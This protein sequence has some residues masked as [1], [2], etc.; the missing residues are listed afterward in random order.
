[1]QQSLD[2]L[3]PRLEVESLQLSTEMNASA[4]DDEQRFRLLSSKPLR[5]E[6]L[7][8]SVSYQ[9]YNKVL[10]S[11]KTR[12][13]SILPDISV[14]PTSLIVL[15][16]TAKT[17]SC[18]PH[19]LSD[20]SLPK[21][22][23]LRDPESMKA[24]E[25]FDLTQWSDRLAFFDIF[26]STTTSR[27]HIPNNDQTLKRMVYSD[28]PF[29]CEGCHE[30]YSDFLAFASHILTC[31][32]TLPPQRQSMYIR[33][34]MSYLKE[35][36]KDLQEWISLLVNVKYS[37]SGDQVPTFIPP[38]LPNTSGIQL[39]T[40][41]E[42]R[43]PTLL[44]LLKAAF[45][46][47]RL[48]DEIEI[49]FTTHLLPQ[50]LDRLNNVYQ[51]FLEAFLSVTSDSLTT[52]ED[53][54][55]HY[56]DQLSE[57]LRVATFASNQDIQTTGS[58]Y[59]SAITI[60]EHLTT[61]DDIQHFNDVVENFSES[62]S[63]FDSLYSEILDNNSFYKSLTG[64]PLSESLLQRMKK[65]LKNKDFYKSISATFS[66][67]T[68]IVE[69]SLFTDHLKTI[70]GFTLGVQILLQS[71]IELNKEVQNDT[72]NQLNLLTLRAA[73]IGV[74][75]KHINQMEDIKNRLDNDEVILTSHL[76]FRSTQYQTAFTD[77]SLLALEDLIQE[78]KQLEYYSLLFNVYIEID[79][80]KQKIRAQHYGEANLADIREWMVQC[81]KKIDKIKEAYDRAAQVVTMSEHTIS[82]QLKQEFQNIQL[83]FNIIFDTSHVQ[84]KLRHWKLLSDNLNQPAIYL[85]AIDTNNET[86]SPL[87][88]TLIDANLSD[89]TDIY[90]NVVKRALEELSVDN[91]FANLQ[92]KWK[93]K[94]VLKLIPSSSFA[95][96]DISESTHF[97]H[98]S[99]TEEEVNL[100]NL[101]IQEK[102]ILDAQSEAENAVLTLD[103]IMNIHNALST[104]L[105]LPLFKQSVSRLPQLLQQ[106][107]ATQNTWLTLRGFLSSRYN[108]T[109]L[110]HILPTFTTA[111]AIWAS[112]I[113]KI[114]NDPH[115]Y[116]TIGV[117]E[118]FSTILSISQDKLNE[119][120]TQ[121]R[122]FVMAMHQSFPLFNLITEKE[123]FE[124]LSYVPKP[125]HLLPI[126]RRIFPGL[127][128]LIYDT[129]Q[130]RRTRPYHH[131]SDHFIEHPLSQSDSHQSDVNAQKPRLFDSFDLDL[132][133]FN[134]LQDKSD[135][136]EPL[137]DK[138]TT[139]LSIDSKHTEN[140]ALKS[141]SFTQMTH[142][143]PTVNEED[144]NLLATIQDN[145]SFG[146]QYHISGITEHFKFCQDENPFPT[147]CIVGIIGPLQ[148][149]VM[150]THSVSFTPHQNSIPFYMALHSSLKQSIRA[151]HLK[152]V[153]RIYPT[154]FAFSRS[155]PDSSESMSD[156]PVSSLQ[157]DLQ[158]PKPNQFIDLSSHNVIDF[159]LT[160]RDHPRYHFEYSRETAD[161]PSML[162]SF[163]TQSIYFS[164]FSLSMFELYRMLMNIL[165]RMSA[166]DSEEW[167]KAYLQIHD[168]NGFDFAPLHS[169]LGRHD[170]ASYRGNQSLPEMVSGLQ[171]LRT[172]FI[173]LTSTIQKTISHRISPLHR[174]RI[175][176]AL[177]ALWPVIAI[178]NTITPL[179]I[180]KNPASVLRALHRFRSMPI[181]NISHTT[182]STR[183]IQETFSS[184]LSDS[185]RYL[186]EK[187]LRDLN[188]LGTYY[189]PIQPP[190][191]LDNVT[192]SDINVSFKHLSIPYGFDYLALSLSSV[193]SFHI[194]TL[195][196]PMHEAFSP[197]LGESE[198]YILATTH[199]WESLVS[200]IVSVFPPSFHTT[201]NKTDSIRNWS[202]H[203]NL[204]PHFTALLGDS[205]YTLSDRIVEL[206]WILGRRV[207]QLT[208]S[209]ESTINETLVRFLKGVVEGGLFG[210]IDGVSM[211]KH[212]N[213]IELA[214]ILNAISEAV[215]KSRSSTIQNII[216]IP[217]NPNFFHFFVSILRGLDPPQLPPELRAQ[218]RLVSVSSTPPLANSLMHLYLN[219]FQYS[220]VLS[221][222]IDHF[223]QQYSLI[224]GQSPN[225]LFG[226]QNHISRIAT[227]YLD[228]VI[229]D[230]FLPVC[231]TSHNITSVTSSPLFKQYFRSTDGSR[232]V[233]IRQDSFKRTDENKNKLR[234]LLESL[235]VCYGLVNDLI[236]LIN[237][238]NV[239]SV[240]EL[241]NNLFPEVADI[242]IDTF[243]F[244]SVST[245]EDSFVMSFNRPIGSALVESNRITSIK[246]LRNGL[247]TYLLSQT[248]F[249]LLQSDI[250]DQLA[251]NLVSINLATMNRMS[252]P[253]VNL[254]RVEQFMMMMK[255][256]PGSSRDYDGVSNQSFTSDSER[257]PPLYDRPSESPPI[258]NQVRNI[259]AKV[260]QLYTLLHPH[261]NLPGAAAAIPQIAPVIVVGPPGSGKTT[262]IML[263]ALIQ[264]QMKRKTRLLH[265]NPGSISIEQLLGS[266]T[267]SMNRINPEAS[268]LSDQ[269]ENLIRE[270]QKEMSHS[271]SLISI[272]TQ[273][274]SNTILQDRPEFHM[275]TAKGA[276]SQN[277]VF[278]PGVVPT[279]LN[280]MTQL[281]A[282]GADS[283][284][285]HTNES[286]SLFDEFFFVLDTSSPLFA[287]PNVLADQLPSSPNTLSQF[288]PSAGWLL[289]TLQWIRTFS[290]FFR[291]TSRLHNSVSTSLIRS[292]LY[293]AIHQKSEN[294]GG[295]LVIPE[296][297][298]DLSIETLINQFLWDDAQSD[299][300]KD[301]SLSHRSFSQIEPE[302]SKYQ[303]FLLDINY[304]DYLLR[305]LILPNNQV[306]V[307]PHNVHYIIETDSLASLPSYVISN[308][309]ILYVP[310]SLFTFYQCTPA[311]YTIKRE[312]M[313]AVLYNHT[314]KTLISHIIVHQISSHSFL[315]QDVILNRTYRLLSNVANRL[316]H[317][318]LK[319]TEFVRDYFDTNKH[320][321][322]FKKVTPLN[323]QERPPHMYNY[324]S[325]YFFNNALRVF[326]SQ[327]K[328]LANFIIYSVISAQ[329]NI[330]ELKSL[331]QMTDNYQ[332]ADERILVAPQ[333]GLMNALTY[334]LFWGPPGV[335]L[336]NKTAITPTPRNSI[337][338]QD[339]GLFIA[340]TTKSTEFEMTETL[341]D[342]FVNLRTG[343]WEHLVNYYKEYQN[344]LAIHR[345][346]K[347]QIR[348][349]RKDGPGLV[350][351][352]MNSPRSTFLDPFDG[353]SMSFAVSDG[354]LSTSPPGSQMHEFTQ[355]SSSGDAYTD[356]KV[357]VQIPQSILYRLPYIHLFSLFIQDDRPFIAAFH[358]N[359][360]VMD[361]LRSIP[362]VPM[363]VYP[364]TTTVPFVATMD[365][366]FFAHTTSYTVARAFSLFNTIDTNV[367]TQFR[368][369]PGKSSPSQ[370]QPEPY[371]ENFDGMMDV[372][373]T[374]HSSSMYDD[375]HSN[376]S[377]GSFGGGS[378]YS[379]RDID[380]Q[381]ESL[382]YE[383]MS[384]NEDGKPANNNQTSVFENKCMLGIFHY[385][386]PVPS[387]T[388][389]QLRA[390]LERRQFILEN[391]HSSVVERR[392][393][394]VRIA[395]SIQNPFAHTLSPRLGRHFQ[396]VALN[397]ISLL[398]MSQYLFTLFTH[399]LHKD[400]D[401]I[402]PLDSQI[403]SLS[404]ADFALCRVPSIT[405]ILLLLFSGSISTIE[406]K[407]DALKTRAKLRELCPTFQVFP[408]TLND[409]V[410]VFHRMFIQF[411]KN[412]KIETDSFQIALTWITEARR[413]FC[414]R[415]PPRERISF[416]ALA[417]TLASYL[418]HQ[419]QIDFDR[420]GHI[421]DC[422]PFVNE[423]ECIRQFLA[424]EL[425][426][427]QARFFINQAEDPE[428]SLGKYLSQSLP[429]IMRDGL[430]YL[431][432]VRNQRVAERLEKSHVAIISDPI[433]FQLEDL[434]IVTKLMKASHIYL[435]ITPSHDHFIRQLRQ[436]CVKVFRNDDE[437]VVAAINVSEVLTLINTTSLFHVQENQTVPL[438]DGS[439]V[440]L[441]TDVAG[442]SVDDYTFMPKTHP[443]MNICDFNPL[444]MF[445]PS[446]ARVGDELTPTDV[447]I[448]LQLIITTPS[449]LLYLLTDQDRNIIM[450]NWMT[451]SNRQEIIE[452][453]RRKLRV[454]FVFT[455]YRGRDDPTSSTRDAEVY[456]QRR[457]H[458]YNLFTESV[459][460]VLPASNILSTFA[461]QV[462]RFDTSNT[463]T[464]TNNPIITHIIVPGLSFFCWA[465]PLCQYEY[466]ETTP[467]CV[468]ES[469]G[470]LYIV[471]TM[472][473]TIHT[474]SHNAKALICEKTINR[475]IRPHNL[476]TKILRDDPT[477]SLELCRSFI[478]I[479]ETYSFN[480]DE[481][482]TS[483]VHD[484]THF[485]T[486]FSTRP[487]PQPKPTYPP[488]PLLNS[489][490][491]VG[492]GIPRM[493]RHKTAAFSTPVEPES[494]FSLNPD[495]DEQIDQ[496]LLSDSPHTH[497]SSGTANDDSMVFDPDHLAVPNG[498]YQQLKPGVVVHPAVLHALERQEERR[499]IFLTEQHPQRP[500]ILRHSVEQRPNLLHRFPSQSTITTMTSGEI[501]TTRLSTGLR[502]GADNHREHL[503]AGKKQPWMNEVERLEKVF[504][505][506]VMRVFVPNDSSRSSLV[507]Q[508]IH[509]LRVERQKLYV[510]VLIAIFVHV[511][512]SF[513]FYSR[514]HASTEWVK[515]R[516]LLLNPSL[517]RKFLQTFTSIYFKRMEVLDQYHR[518][519]S[520]CSDQLAVILTRTEPISNLIPR[521]LNGSFE[522]ATQHG[523]LVQCIHLCQHLMG[524]IRE[525]QPITQQQ[526]VRL[527]EE[528]K[529]KMGE[530]EAL[531][532]EIIVQTHIIDLEAI[533]QQIESG[534]P[535]MTR[536]V[537][538][539]H[540][541]AR[542]VLDM[543]L[544]LLHKPLKPTELFYIRQKR[545]NSGSSVRQSSIVFIRD[546]VSQDQRYV[547]QSSFIHDVLSAKTRT[548][549][550]EQAELVEP[551]IDFLTNRIDELSENEQIVDIFTYV[552]KLLQCRFKVDTA[553]FQ[554][555]KT[556]HM[557]KSLEGNI[558]TM[559]ELTRELSNY[560]ILLSTT[561]HFLA[562]AACLERHGTEFDSIHPSHS[563]D[564]PNEPTP[565]LSRQSEDDLSARS[566]Y[567]F[568][569]N[570]S[571]IESEDSSIPDHF[572][573]VNPSLS[574]T[575]TPSSMN[576]EVSSYL[577]EYW[578][579]QLTNI[580]KNIINA[581][582]DSILAAAFSVFQ[583]AIP[584]EE[585][586]WCIREW[587]KIL[588]MA[589]IE[590]SDEETKDPSQTLQELSSESLLS[591][592]P[593]LSTIDI[594]YG[595]GVLLYPQPLWV[596]SNFIRPLF[597][598]LWKILHGPSSFWK[599]QADGL[600]PDEQ[601]VLNGCL[602]A[603]VEGVHPIIFVDPLH[604]AQEWM[605]KRYRRISPIIVT[606]ILEKSFFQNCL[607]ALF[608]GY[609][610]FIEVV[611]PEGIADPERIVN[612]AHMMSTLVSCA[613]MSPTRSIMI[614]DQEIKLKEG[615]RLFIFLQDETS[616]LPSPFGL[617]FSST[618]QSEL[619][620]INWSPI[621][622]STSF[623]TQLLHTIIIPRLFPSL[624]EQSMKTLAQIQK[625]DNNEQTESAQFTQS[626]YQ[627]RE[628]PTK[629]YIHSIN[630]S[631]AGV[632]RSAEQRVELIR[633]A[634]A[635][636]KIFKIG[637]YLSSYARDI[638]T[639]CEATSRFEPYQLLPYSSLKTIITS[640]TCVHGIPSIVQF[641]SFLQEAITT[642]LG[643][644]AIQENKR[645]FQQFLDKQSKN[646]PQDSLQSFEPVDDSTW[647]TVNTLSPD[648]LQKIS[649][650]SQTIQNEVAAGPHLMMETVKSLISRIIHS[651]RLYSPDHNGNIRLEQHPY[652][653]LLSLSLTRNLR[654]RITRKQVKSNEKTGN[655]WISQSLL[656]VVSFRDVRIP[657]PYKDAIR[658]N[659][660]REEAKLMLEGLFAP[661]NIERTIDTQTIPHT[662]DDE[663]VKIGDSYI[664]KSA[665]QSH[666][667]DCGQ[668]LDANST[669]ET[670][671]YTQFKESEFP[672]VNGTTPW[673]SFKRFQRIY[674]QRSLFFVERLVSLS[675][676]VKL[677]PTIPVEWL[678]HKLLGLSNVNM[679]TISTTSFSFSIEPYLT[680]YA[681]SQVPAVYSNPLS[682]SLSLPP[683]AIVKY[684]PGTSEKKKNVAEQQLFRTFTFL[685]SLWMTIP[686]S[687][688][689]KAKI[690]L[691]DNTIVSHPVFGHLPK[692][693][694]KTFYQSSI[695]LKTKP[696]WS[697]ILQTKEL[698]K[699]IHHV[700]QM[701]SFVQNL[702]LSPPLFVATPTIDRMV[703]LY[704]D[705]ESPFF[706][707][708]SK[709][710]FTLPPLQSDYASLLA[711]SDLRRKT[712]K[713]L[714]ET[715]T[716][717]DRHRWKLFIHDGVLNENHRYRQLT[718]TFPF[719]LYPHRPINFTKSFVL[720]PSDAV[721]LSLITPSA[722]TSL[723]LEID[724]I[725]MSFKTA[726]LRFVSWIPPDIYHAPGIEGWS[727]L[728]FCCC[729]VHALLS[730]RQ[731]Y[732]T[733]LYGSILSDP[734]TYPSADLTIR[735]MVP[736][737]H[738][739][740]VKFVGVVN[741]FHALMQSTVETISKH[742]L[743]AQPGNSPENIWSV[744]CQLSITFTVRNFIT[745]QVSD[746]II[747]RPENLAFLNRVV[748]MYV[749]KDIW[750]PSF[751]YVNP[752]QLF[753]DPLVT[754]R[755]SSQ[756]GSYNFPMRLKGPFFNKEAIM[757]D[758][759]QKFPENSAV[760]QIIGIA[761]SHTYSAAN[762]SFKSIQVMMN[763]M[764]RPQHAYQQLME[765]TQTRITDDLLHTKEEL[766]ALQPKNVP[767]RR[768]KIRTLVE[769]TAYV[770][771]EEVDPFDDNDIIASFCTFI[772]DVTRRM[773]LP[774]QYKGAI[775]GLL[776]PGRS[777][778][779]LLT[780]IM[781][782]ELYRH[783][784]SCMSWCCH[785]VHAVQFLAPPATLTPSILSYTHIF[786][787]HHTRTMDF[788]AKEAMV[789]LPLPAHVPLHGHAIPHWFSLSHDSIITIMQQLQDQQILVFPLSLLYDPAVLLA[790]ITQDLFSTFRKFLVT[791]TTFST[792]L[793]TMQTDFLNTTDPQ[794][795]YV[796]PRFFRSPFVPESLPFNAPSNPSAFIFEH[797][798]MSFS[799]IPID[800][801]TSS[802][803][804]FF[805]FPD[806][807]QSRGQI[808]TGVSMSGFAYNYE[809]DSFIH[810]S[811]HSFLP[812]KTTKKPLIWVSQAFVST[813]SVHQ[814][815][816]D[817]V[818]RTPTASLEVFSPFFQPTHTPPR[819]LPSKSA[820]TM[821]FT[822][823]PLFS[824]FWKH[825]VLRTVLVVHPHFSSFG[826][827][828][829][830]LYVDF[831]G[832]LNRTFISHK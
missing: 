605:M 826:L 573:P 789:I 410:T 209:P 424:E 797:A 108:Q 147:Y 344:Q 598:P 207:V 586:E 579:F 547:V 4:L 427:E 695:P 131:Q 161:V 95:S 396:V 620:V 532:S 680:K 331:D 269:E 301:P 300:K 373:D 676:N 814:A 742:P 792:S 790:S 9:M 337:A 459:E 713:A 251:D 148:E 87:F 696:L 166:D 821:F 14:S 653:I 647:E 119:C 310:P 767:Q 202:P 90:R 371:P 411:N 160:L 63:L 288:Q 587:Q 466:Y 779:P 691:N 616:L 289:E 727:I 644:V 128:Y 552:V 330:S 38:Q 3:I 189:N 585:L 151:N 50:L 483:H 353:L 730:I 402:T 29:F 327:F 134:E 773:P 329:Q 190:N 425:N 702:S 694:L 216:Q 354:T 405:H 96:S 60:A 782:K 510:S 664:P 319:A 786:S 149:N 662:P 273:L 296:V 563:I 480:E 628:Y 97:L 144:S 129:Q 170:T 478:N 49:D 157:F 679:P 403:A 231:D 102:S 444:T 422:L 701:P 813:S 30:I 582:G 37:A 66:S 484:K 122:P 302:S 109:T 356:K 777:S 46:P 13:E 674:P 460:Q 426:S 446:S 392:S 361:V 438:V 142:E 641:L 661:I 788:F 34:R 497:W 93:E 501:I 741:Q 549:T 469:L 255:K 778:H 178:L 463:A 623:D 110:S 92:K 358:L 508:A 306:I 397:D 784:V 822:P 321:E 655:H 47:V 808:F 709:S 395:L 525:L 192:E 384:D 627:K 766:E 429:T 775:P 447:S 805:T 393:E 472:V 59:Q 520:T 670:A 250:Y 264:T 116:E 172:E 449:W 233:E 232:T 569:S 82:N 187:P 603:N 537:L 316:T 731:A 1:M 401:Y 787:P 36:L 638:W 352:N 297:D 406:Y 768:K 640:A 400:Y 91:E 545:T 184:L 69:K 287:S 203:E 455:D 518:T 370:S 490:F 746:S 649:T 524:K 734:T 673:E 619:T 386:P 687:E 714:E 88:S 201:S 608:S 513:H 293:S 394:H 540:Q 470:P 572:S 584:F 185:Q 809:T 699:F 689:T 17:R 169:L 5:T 763:H 83:H 555:S 621:S 220:Q 581:A 280:T 322:R 824:S 437:K 195:M 12:F 722:T 739:S 657:R 377:P 650:L 729:V 140:E 801:N 665:I 566:E 431:Q 568:S 167:T 656:S 700:K 186:T 267:S 432:G 314:I 599:H 456:L 268:S 666:V 365:F 659:D 710:S 473:E 387:A 827:T 80:Q 750:T 211:L 439:T 333:Q 27:Y 338:A 132:D 733:S 423:D 430:F 769:Y 715:I 213:L 224:T 669:H 558:H 158:T 389:D 290:P 145:E 103:T 758:V 651:I 115:P 51:T 10:S 491:V 164:L 499:S 163:M 721:G 366:P 544:I 591:T 590:Y 19:K 615:F 262:I 509:G 253:N 123:V 601:S 634:D 562:Q 564:S 642:T 706:Q 724:S 240:T 514:I 495:S 799:F 546:T 450:S 511:R 823:A 477:F 548:I 825:S 465:L 245:E 507:T 292:H 75:L 237:A 804:L 81:R 567:S 298:I 263:L 117:S 646:F 101:K 32:E 435:S 592:P 440:P 711:A 339:I 130:P 137:I 311:F 56:M 738:W 736:V 707:S 522:Y 317:Y 624:Y 617:M 684:E 205:P 442:N 226:L 629:V 72:T 98:D 496:S 154:M 815:I 162:S 505:D 580:R 399:E 73:Q 279:I 215:S 191:N 265:L 812:P 626:L 133:V 44:A 515:H 379:A 155:E 796:I 516:L 35:S 174:Q 765:E 312:S 698:Q 806:L 535:L 378:T 284:I 476:L 404:P 541:Y 121:V 493:H 526:R 318:V 536:N 420:L 309:R 320:P 74:Y 534:R 176:H 381:D 219:R 345:Q 723:N 565:A 527:S 717:S 589:G 677:K 464:L 398:H 408:L 829:C 482:G 693:F 453:I 816:F 802:S 751:D 762:S 2:E 458:Q 23:E 238:D 61:P 111:E 542:Y 55:D 243:K 362:G 550:D 208:L 114:K 445:L 682:I 443:P 204:T 335:S 752:P 612:I 663:F 20:F 242:V 636:R 304:A 658:L 704:Q 65:C 774:Y 270:I 645:H 179:S 334:S 471:P 291:T 78:K 570:L 551:Y 48:T 16:R 244:D 600:P 112:L 708:T 15:I 351:Q 725:D 622:Y 574:T 94:I 433:S 652:S 648:D 793:D 348:R 278:R 217:Q 107:L 239:S 363:S 230:F 462:P 498:P 543:C 754:N 794:Q 177:A 492:V 557:R 260:Q 630:T 194:S 819:V 488:P 744:A 367:T 468:L 369:K 448:Y 341:F 771:S 523:T 726:I 686:Q 308:S 832:S 811:N 33:G 294:K 770:P 246:R 254:S 705:G 512:D 633:E 126:L 791:L 529:Q 225:A 743:K 188:G 818:S 274:S 479:R 530:R 8:H 604:V 760:H 52:F 681:L 199:F 391:E 609:P 718:T 368:P 602:T 222:K 206:G 451:T 436:L 347:N 776:K 277:T 100:L 803:E 631:F 57:L 360:D 382:Y 504:L 486:I 210:F 241:L 588:E 41:S 561:I 417:T 683:F 295:S 31:P 474:N 380:F 281:S 40:K 106:L 595:D 635:F 99:L 342:Y 125:E 252:K 554:L 323:T 560:Q 800:P 678:I 313:F 303:Q 340:N 675:T 761:P 639:V 607:D 672:L 183:M 77:E 165:C 282:T 136:R 613:V 783:Q 419:G 39:N 614:Y 372:G 332:P 583:S 388:I 467:A 375:M 712:K 105:D 577:V 660:A 748:A 781:R 127:L 62:L 688:V 197:D 596:A 759:S 42:V 764:C 104:F 228:I 416:D 58:S 68:I 559:G 421:V 671:T 283:S 618:A 461:G 632:T 383:H 528:L 418:L 152:T 494:F 266:Y 53:R 305:A 286:D 576:M 350:R 11:F 772:H 24:I 785:K 247:E 181:T 285:R 454:V 553:K 248:S 415:L 67:S 212:S 487:P 198:S 457:L 376:S 428:S 159:I 196:N 54:I 538:S 259:I 747:A 229:E 755:D 374:I 385:I 299:D 539:F 820:K 502:L 531:H 79:K 113:L 124:A 71:V 364:I 668:T 654:E 643:T 697:Q 223:C 409:C 485:S 753:K 120:M 745:E 359:T 70:K 506:Q 258:K 135:E 728:L 21:S 756:I 740:Q 807:R 407:P 434:E 349:Q 357:K 828:G 571:D 556:E 180:A 85:S 830:F 193:D 221:V 735:G 138:D 667:E 719:T 43:H 84:M 593:H 533:R 685:T 732:H 703:H 325:R 720:P 276:K 200:N 64:Q 76:Q 89:N 168:L 610:L 28:T 517:F 817:P 594:G 625:L 214:S 637:G 346:K 336:H 6:F 139:P 182:D 146:E 611:S 141:P 343:T 272:F 315:H 757:K 489:V 414:M 275:D 575:P 171:S 118:H 261:E 452:K 521:I 236:P 692:Q 716:D 737:D 441:G 175:E 257:T 173:S 271:S 749:C 690:T 7:I 475:S 597:R 413:V 780:Q 519:V 503:A 831:D 249:S 156:T 26:V 234:Y 153:I 235:S 256:T 218:F 18:I 412:R 810:S 795:A 45:E 390:Y 324:T 86:Q 328:Y 143:Y 481:D 22:F 500:Q 25:R 307:S 798:M 606:H 227:D 150:L 326:L 578:K 355:P